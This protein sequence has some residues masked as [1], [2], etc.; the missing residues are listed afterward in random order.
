MYLGGLVA[1]LFPRGTPTLA[2]AVLL[3]V[4]AFALGYLSWDTF[5]RL[6]AVHS[7]PLRVGGKPLTKQGLQW[8]LRI[9][10]AA[11][12]VVFALCA[13]RLVFI[14]MRYEIDLLRLVSDPELW[15]RYLVMYVGQT[16]YETHATTIA[17][18]ICNSLFSIG[19]V[20]LG[21]SL[22]IGTRRNRYIYVLL[23]LT[24]SI[25]IGLVNLN[26]KEVMVNILF[27]VFSYLFVHSIA[28]IRTR[29]EMIRSLVCPM[30]FLFLLFVLIEL[31]LNKGGTFGP[32]NRVTGFLFSI[33]WSIA[34]PL[35]ALGEFIRDFKGDYLLGESLFFPIHKWLHRFGLVS[36]SELAVFSE[37]LYIPYVANV[38]S[39]LRNV[40]EDFGMLGVA[41]VPYL[42][43]WG[44][45]A[46]RRTA[47]VC[48]AG[49]N[50]Y[51]ILL[52]LIFF[53]FY[54]YVFASNQ[55]Y[56]QAVFGWLFFRY[57]LRSLG[58]YDPQ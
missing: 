6:E 24:L 23:F 2:W 51:L 55:F 39:Y 49:F 19:F 26:R 8:S 15:R 40:Y 3:N 7:R 11:G 48:F 38:Y 53:S 43:G 4:G 34:S 35:A 58:E 22:Y 28:R 12:V 17:I 21:I 29:S 33:Y 36:Q 50:L 56:L 27:L 47:Q 46:L 16:V 18:S 32:R 20:L 10:W 1:G 52:V 57:D 54:N 41:I 31:L 9:T 30:A 14:S 45:S 25:I 37:K 44:V 42:L 13:L 5:R